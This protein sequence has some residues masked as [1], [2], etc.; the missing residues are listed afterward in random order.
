MVAT[1][2]SV[3]A[4]LNLCAVTLFVHLTVKGGAAV[5]PVAGQCPADRVAQ[6]S[7]LSID[8]ECKGGFECVGTH[9]CTRRLHSAGS[10]QCNS[11][12]DACVTA[13]R[14]TAPLE[15]STT[16]PASR[17]NLVGS[18]LW[19]GQ[20]VP[21]TSLAV[22][23]PGCRGGQAGRACARPA[24]PCRPAGRRGDVPHHNK[25]GLASVVV[26]AGLWP[27]AP[28][29]RHPPGT[30]TRSARTGGAWGSG[31]AYEAPEVDER[32]YDGVRASA[33]G[34]PFCSHAP[35]HNKL[36][37]KRIGRNSPHRGRDTA[38]LDQPDE[39]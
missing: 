4:P 22:R 23:L 11:S 9:Q 13:P 8:Q 6:Q 29:G 27:H 14:L 16:L 30:I 15:A 18:Y 5:V 28:G 19:I 31:G 33:H 17:P 36:S 2:L 12:A 26:Q 10:R 34:Q 25:A 32:Q 1:S 21:A 20:C 39:E 35:V 3:R 7:Q 38:P 37:L 24:A